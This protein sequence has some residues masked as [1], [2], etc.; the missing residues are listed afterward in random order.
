M[1]ES[2]R[3]FNLE[4]LIFLFDNRILV[5]LK[6]ELKF[7]YSDIIAIDIF[8]YFQFQVMMLNIKNLENILRNSF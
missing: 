2:T 4:L 8:F 5:Y 1:V 3:V 7:K 6:I